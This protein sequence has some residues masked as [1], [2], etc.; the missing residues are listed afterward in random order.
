M[1]DVLDTAVVKLECKSLEPQHKC[2][3]SLAYL[4]L[5][6]AKIYITLEIT[7]HIARLVKVFFR[8]SYNTPRHV[9]SANSTKKE[10]KE[11]TK[12]WTV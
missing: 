1:I 11:S 4:V 9:L 5:G 7:K 8:Q 12:L 2:F 6:D 3:L 10:K